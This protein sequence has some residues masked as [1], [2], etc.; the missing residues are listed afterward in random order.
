MRKWQ[1]VL[2]SVWLGALLLMILSSVLPVFADEGPVG[3]AVRKLDIPAEPRIVYVIPVQ[4]TIESGLEKFLQRAFREAEAGSADLIIVEINTLGGELNAAFDIGEL[5]R[6]SPV[7]TIAYIKGK[8]ISAGSYIALNALQIYMDPGSSMGAAAMVS[9]G[10]RV[11]DSKLISAWSAEMRSVAEMNGRNPDYAVGMVD[12]RK[13]IDIPELG[14]QSAEGELITFTADEAVKTGYAEGMAGSRQM[15]LESLNAATADVYEVELR[16]SEKLAR[17]LTHP[18]VMTLLLLVGL[19]GVAIEIFVPGFGLPGILGIA[20]F[21]LY[22]SG[23]YIAGFA[24]IEHI[25]LFVVGVVLLVIEVFVPSFGIIG[26]LGLASLVGGVVLAAADT[27]DALVSL[28]IASAV[29]LV[30]LIAVG[31]IFKQRGV[32]NKFVLKEELTK[33]EGFSSMTSKDDLLGM[34]GEAVTALRPSGV[35]LIADKRVDVVTSG[36]F[37]TPGQSIVVIQIEGTRVVVREKK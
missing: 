37:I 16:P 31:Y 14:I 9:G 26:V 33:E 12:D 29:A 27:G 4:Q 6:F 28:S 1:Q 22:F 32:W 19:A 5:I 30:V 20:G 21:V 10:E 25:I 23:Q 24:G 35:A 15:L 17:F 7:P 36:E 11:T 34:T 13:A 8:A 2:R 18:T 3:D